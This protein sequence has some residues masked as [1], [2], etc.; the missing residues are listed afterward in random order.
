MLSAVALAGTLLAGFSTAPASTDATFVDA[1]TSAGNAMTTGQLAPPTNPAATNGTTVTVSWTATTTTSATGYRIYRSDTSGVQ[2]ALVATVTPRTATSWV[3]NSPSDGKNFYIIKTYQQNWESGDIV[4][5]VGTKP[6][7]VT[8]EFTGTGA[9]G[10]SEVGNRPWQSLNGSWTRNSGTATT[11]TAHTSNPMMVVDMA[12]SNA[13]IT[14]KTT[15][16]RSGEAIYFRVADGNNWL[17]ARMRRHY[18]T[19]QYYV[20][21]Y[22]HTTYKTEYEYET[23]RARTEYEYV[24]YS[25]TYGPWSAW[26]DSGSTTV[27]RTDGPPQSGANTYYGAGGQPIEENRWVVESTC[28]A[29]GGS[30]YKSQK[31]TRAEY[32]SGNYTWAYSQPAGYQPTGNSRTVYVGEGRYYWATSRAYAEDQPTGASRQV[33]DSQYWSTTSCGGCPTRQAGPYTNTNNDYYV[34]VEKSVGGIITQLGSYAG[35]YSSLRVLAQGSTIQVYGATSLLATLTDSTHQN[36]TLWGVGLGGANA[37]Y[38]S[39]NVE[40]VDIQGL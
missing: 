27:C 2:G 17:R 34:V 21:E 19:S 37:D 3:D 29:Q 9:L 35:N 4:E 31:R 16:S 32:A 26:T 13:D 14:S 1:T 36:A 20:T 18:Y 23:Y 12:S 33:V 15:S 22:Q 25:Y 5:S 28:T 24:Y 7:R 8:D 30:R 6:I 40:S 39:N 10:N 38:P 11:T